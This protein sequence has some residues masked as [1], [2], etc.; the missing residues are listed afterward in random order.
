MEVFYQ[1][2]GLSNIYENELSYIEIANLAILTQ[3]I[4]N[5]ESFISDTN[6]RGARF[7]LSDA[8]EDYD[9]Y[10]KEGNGVQMMTIHSAKGLE[11]PVTIISSLEKDK[12]P[13]IN[14][15]PEREKD[16]VFPND[17]YYTPQ[18]NV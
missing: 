13:M 16:N 3:S 9:S 8:I 12:F 2:I 4:S 15:D 7:F 6:F 17:T 1:L 18:M 5:Y 10:Q 11:F 14:K